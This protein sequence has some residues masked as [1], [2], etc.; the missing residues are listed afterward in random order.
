MTDGTGNL[1][2]FTAEP[3]EV[4]VN[5]VLVEGDTELRDIKPQAEIPTAI[6]LY[7][8]GGGL[9]LAAL[10]AGLFWLARRRKAVPAVVDNRT[11]YQRAG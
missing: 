10:A 8:V 9:A 7:V 3:I 11:P 1:Y 2:E 6:W 5:S 4:T